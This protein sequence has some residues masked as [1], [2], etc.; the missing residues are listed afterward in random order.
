MQRFAGATPSQHATARETE[1]R[2]EDAV[3]R[4]NPRY[5]ETFCLRAYC[6]MPYSEIAAAMDL[7]SENTANVMFLRARTELQKRLEQ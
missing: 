1:A 5:R 2:L 7:P 6:R 3:R 4:I